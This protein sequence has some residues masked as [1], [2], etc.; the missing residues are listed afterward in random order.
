M[1]SIMSVSP[2]SSGGFLT[3][4]LAAGFGR[5]WPGVL[6]S[7]DTQHRVVALTFDDGPTPEITPGL[8]E[9][10][11]RHGATATF[12]LIGERAARHPQLVERIR[13]DGHE[14]GNHLWSD[15][16]SS[17]LS[18]A[19]FERQ[20][21]A[22]DA[23]IAPG[24]S[25]KWFRPGHGVCTRDQ[26]ELARSHGYRC[27]LVSVYSHDGALR[28]AGWISSITLFETF[29][30]AIIV[31][32]DGAEERKAVIAATDAV[33]RRLGERGFRCVSVST[34][35]GLGKMERRRA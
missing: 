28:N 14:L 30:G 12:F 9:V 6:F 35:A 2:L 21:L 1:R 33:L 27:C 25:P 13:A 19:E 31:L 22:V 17:A 20:L 32:H 18:N 23:L 34:L 10:L 24:T 5:L 16:R 11:K 15:T 29:P 8:L 4:A 7:V 26:I 3:R